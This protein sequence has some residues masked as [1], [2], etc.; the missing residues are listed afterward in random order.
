MAGEQTVRKPGPRVWLCVA[1]MVLGVLVAALPTVVVA[2]RAVRTLSTGEVT[3]P[4]TVERSLSAG[5]WVIYQRTGTTVDG[6]GFTTTHNGIP[7]LSP[8]EVSVTDSSGRP[9]AVRPVTFNETITKGSRIYTGAVQFRVTRRDV[10]RIQ[11]I[12]GGSSAVLI[13]RSFGDTF[14]NF[15]ALAVVGSAGGF[16]F[17]LGLVLLIVG[18]VRRSTR[19][20][21]VM[22]AG[23]L[24]AQAGLAPP[25]WYPDPQAPGK[26]RWWD[27]TRW[28]DHRA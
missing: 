27:G 22:P 28:T 8:D 4:T 19:K 12:T 11:V 20:Q 16:I 26:L 3:T 13:A 24:A 14:R 6:G 2:V 25:A 21:G 10:Y 5:T 18:V 17:V 7:D 1:V 9:I 15:V 23:H